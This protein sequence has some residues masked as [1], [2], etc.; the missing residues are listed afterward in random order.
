MPGDLVQNIE[1]FIEHYNHHRYHES[2]NN[3]IPADLYFGRDHAILEERR[4]IKTQ[5]IQNRRLQH[6][7]KAA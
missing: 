1:A 6:Q 3:L 2:I 4:K 5:T 7:H